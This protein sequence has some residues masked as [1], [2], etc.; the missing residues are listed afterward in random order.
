MVDPT[1]AQQPSARRLSALAAARSAA[2]S[3]RWR[4]IRSWSAI[5]TRRRPLAP[6]ARLVNGPCPREVRRICTVSQ[7]SEVLA[8]EWNLDES[9][10]DP[11]VA[12]VQRGCS[13]ACTLTSRTFRSRIVWAWSGGAAH[14]PTGLALIVKQLHDPSLVAPRR[15]ATRLRRCL[16]VPSRLERQ[17]SLRRPPHA[18]EEATLTVRPRAMAPKRPSA[19]RPKARER[20][21]IGRLL[22]SGEI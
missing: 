17:A 11:H 6:G 9:T 22:P 7:F 18:H 12:E 16:A 4:R 3:S 1:F 2:T 19:C 20:T 10:G 21:D 15:Y 14:A 5:V 13:A 8:A